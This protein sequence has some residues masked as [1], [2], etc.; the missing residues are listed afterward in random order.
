MASHIGRRKLL[1]TLG[2][3]SMA[4]RGARAASGDAD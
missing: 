1:A 3:G 2:G 4:A